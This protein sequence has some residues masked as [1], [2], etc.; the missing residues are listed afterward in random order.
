MI[1]KT[2]ISSIIT[3]SLTINLF[4]S[5]ATTKIDNSEKNAY[6]QNDSILEEPSLSTKPATPA[7]YETPQ[8]NLRPI[9]EPYYE[10]SL[11]NK[12]DIKIKS[13]NDSIL[14]EPSLSTKPAT[15][16]DYETPQ[17]NLRPIEE[18]YYEEHSNIK[19]NN[20]TIP[21]SH[22][23]QNNKAEKELPNTGLDNNFH[24]EITILLLII[25]S[26]IILRNSI[27]KLFV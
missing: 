3:T 26:F 14:E 23:S 4:D 13:Q 24:K 17:E 5:Y 7:D 21:K 8:E 2:I 20:D 18:P 11:N 9:E 25:G 27:V 12:Q 1:K 10:E 22:S 15:P 16:A 19:E 6:E